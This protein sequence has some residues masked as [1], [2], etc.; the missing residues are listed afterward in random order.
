MSASSS[1]FARFFAM[2]IASRAATL[3]FG[4]NLALMIGKIGVG[5]VFGSVAVL[6]DGIDSAQDVFA[7]ALAFFAVRLAM[8]PADERH[9]FGHG[10]AEGLAAMAQA[11][12][13]VG[14][15]GFIAVTAV[16][17]L[18]TGGVEIYVWPSVIAML[19][20]VAVNLSVAAYA[21]RAAR[22]SGSVAIASDARHLLTNV[23]QAGGVIA[24]LVLV[25]VT[26][27]HWFDPAVALILAAYLTW[28]A[29]TIARDAFGE[30]FDEALPEEDVD[31]IERLLEGDRHGVRGH[32]G[33]RTRKSGRERY[34]DVHV[35]VDPALTV[36]E[37]HRLVEEIEQHLVDVVP[38]AMV[39]VHIDPDE[40]GIM[41][42]HPERPAV[43][44]EQSLH[45]HQH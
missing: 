19:V 38:G 44:V 9:P 1:P 26:G 16:Y 37:A 7:S 11:A 5:L 28:I 39:N 10:K 12:L 29:F 24:G 23:V 6:G 33:L 21:L 31:A 45:L 18:A 35:L 14:G 22:I 20:T 41:D 8:Q 3:S 34:I 4:S 42:R 13:I 25:G 17:R 36:S 15:A 40:P 32:H 27:E 30:L 2:D 43:S